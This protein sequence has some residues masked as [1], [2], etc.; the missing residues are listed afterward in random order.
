MKQATMLFFA[1]ASTMIL[2][3]CDQE[4]VEKTSSQGTVP[5][6]VTADIQLGIEQYIKDQAALADGYFE[7]P[8]EDGILRLKLVRVRDNCSQTQ[9]PTVL[10]LGTGR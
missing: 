1:L 3:S 2:A 5:H 7:L 9:R 4:K 10:Y 6:V 8:F